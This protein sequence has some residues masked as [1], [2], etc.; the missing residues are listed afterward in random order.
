MKHKAEYDAVLRCAEFVR[1][2][3][4]THKISAK[5]ACR[6]IGIHVH[7]VYAWEHDGAA[8]GLYVLQALYCAGANLDYIMTGR[9]YE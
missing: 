7:S 3:A 8:P 6:R 1:D 9:R 4:E 2:Y 5:E